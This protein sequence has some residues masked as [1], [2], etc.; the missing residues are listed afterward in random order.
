MAKI[1]TKVKIIIVI[2]FFI[3]FVLVWHFVANSNTAKTNNLEYE[4]QNSVCV[5]LS[6]YFQ[7][8]SINNADFSLYGDIMCIY[9]YSSWDNYND[10]KY[11]HEYDYIM[12]TKDN[13]PCVLIFVDNRYQGDYI[14]EK[15][16]DS[17]NI[18]YLIAKKY[19][20]E[21]VQT[22]DTSDISMDIIFDGYSVS[23]R[24]G[25]QYFDDDLAY[26]WNNKILH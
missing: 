23:Q 16:N 4:S 6:N 17:D 2:C 25:C 9:E 12:T 11:L 7:E 24:V 3:M 22:Y 20:E 8:G 26:D 14:F 10:S 15:E 21:K 13:Q 19:L 18:N 1:S 5:S